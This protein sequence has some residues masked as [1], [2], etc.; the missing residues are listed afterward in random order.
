MNTISQGVS[1]ADFYMTVPTALV[2]FLET[3]SRTKTIA[4]PQLRGAEG[5][6]LTLNLGDDVPVLQTVFGAAA[7]GGFATIPQSSYTYRSV[8]VNV[9]VT[10]RVTYEGEIILELVVENSTLG[11]SIDVGGQ[12]APTFGTRKVTTKLRMREGESNLLA[13]LLREDDRRSLSRLPGA[14]AA[15][16]VQAVPVE[17]RSA[18]R[19]RPT[20]SCC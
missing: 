2:R 3:D 13:G 4:K 5:T 17:Q 19:R 11:G 1:T 16:G 18:D 10:P 20:S 9:E 7:Q 15:A 8:G 12:S 6:K 14:A